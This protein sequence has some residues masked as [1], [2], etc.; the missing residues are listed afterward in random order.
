[1]PQYTQA[2]AQGWVLERLQRIDAL[3]A[4]VAGLRSKG[5]ADKFVA[6]YNQGR[7]LAR[8]KG[9]DLAA[10][11][12]FMIRRGVTHHSDAMH[13]P[14]APRPSSN[15]GAG[16]SDFGK[17]ITGEMDMEAWTNKQI[18]AVSEEAQEEYGY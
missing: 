6:S 11:E 14:G 15:W 8:D 2:E 5:E 9:Y 1:M 16:D 4:E 13:L 12:N 18:Q 10:L 17:V 3:E 7:K